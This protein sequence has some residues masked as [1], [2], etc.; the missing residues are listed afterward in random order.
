MQ[1]MTSPMIGSGLADP[2]HA[3]DPHGRDRAQDALSFDR[4]WWLNSKSDIRVRRLTA[5]CAYLPF[6]DSNMLWST[7]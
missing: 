6:R 7:I 5:F 1:A 4:A 2:Q 3:W